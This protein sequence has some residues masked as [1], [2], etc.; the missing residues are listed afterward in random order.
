MISIILAFVLGIVEASRDMI[1]FRFD[2]SIFRYLNHEY[3]DPKRSFPR[4]YNM[5]KL[6]TKAPKYYLGLYTPPY[7]EKFPYST[8]F[9]VFLTDGWH[10][11]KALYIFNI[12]T[13]VLTY[14]PIVGIVE[15]T[16]IFFIVYS[17]SFNLFENKLLKASTYK[18]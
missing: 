7:T 5:S 15:D 2:Y 18:K 11:L 14:S 6:N 1:S 4:K 9:L 3:W 8:T 12:I 10:L 16:W 17:F 13:L